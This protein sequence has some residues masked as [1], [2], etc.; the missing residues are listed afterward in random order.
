MKTN[1]RVNIDP[2]LIAKR[3]PQADHIL[4]LQAA[5][6]TE[7]FVPMLTGSLRDRTKVEGGK[8]IYEG[9]Y[10]HYL[11][12]GIVY[13]D[14][15][16]GY[17]GIPTKYGWFSRKGVTKVPSNRK[18]DIRK[19]QDHWFEASKAINMDKWL[20]VYGRALKSGD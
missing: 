13:V 20:R 4:A 3:T 8:I 7:K 10:A 12:V 11:Y 14:P 2:Q 18:L 15:E 16:T 6:D 19:G 1:V 17:A 5:K 9:P